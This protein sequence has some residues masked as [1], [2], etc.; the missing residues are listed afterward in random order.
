M[1]TVARNFRGKRMKASISMRGDGATAV[2]IFNS[3]LDFD[4]AISGVFH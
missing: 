2:P 1:P 4:S 3:K